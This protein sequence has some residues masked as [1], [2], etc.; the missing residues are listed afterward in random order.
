MENRKQRRS[1]LVQLSSRGSFQEG[2]SVVTV[3]GHVC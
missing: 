1:D 3:R 2:Q